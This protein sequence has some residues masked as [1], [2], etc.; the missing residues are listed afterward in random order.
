MIAAMRQ[1]GVAYHGLSI[2]GGGSILSGVVLGAMTTFIVDRNFAKASG[3]A[4]A[5]AV[6][7][8]FGLMHGE[9]VG[10]FQN[11]T[12][13]VAYL[14]V[15][16]VLFGCSRFAAVAPV[17]EDAHEEHEEHEAELATAE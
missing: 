4:A 8:F 12:V 10:A 2:L 5:G 17:A 16:G 7:T 9:E 1:V 15:A 6:L 13:V 11:P 3:F 14:A